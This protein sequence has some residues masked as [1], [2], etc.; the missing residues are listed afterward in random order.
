VVWQDRWEALA[1]G[2]LCEPDAAWFTPGAATARATSPTYASRPFAGSTRLDASAG[3][4]FAVRSSITTLQTDAVANETSYEEP[5]DMCT[6]R[7]E[8]EVAEGTCRAT[9][10]PDDIRKRWIGGPGFTVGRP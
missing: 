6:L 5:L 9:D 7:L 1:A 4:R 8:A 3:L 10:V 2:R